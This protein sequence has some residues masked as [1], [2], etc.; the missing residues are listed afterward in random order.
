M[1][2]V[3]S[4]EGKKREINETVIFYQMSSRGPRCSVNECLRARRTQGYCN[5]H[6]K[7][8]GFLGTSTN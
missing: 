6:A 2:D 5:K 4:M 1:D 3:L 7:A 8:K